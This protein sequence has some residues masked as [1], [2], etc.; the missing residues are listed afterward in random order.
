MARTSKT[1]LQK[2][3][4][5][6]SRA[7][8]DGTAVEPPSKEF[9]PGGC[10]FGADFKIEKT[11][12][13]LG[14]FVSWT[15]DVVPQLKEWV[16]VLVSQRPYF[17]RAWRKL[18]KGRWVARNHGLP[19]DVAM[20]PPS[21]DADV[22]FESPAPRQGDEKKIKRAP[23]SPNSKK[24][25][26]NKRSRQPKGSTDALSSDSIHRLRDE[27]EEEEDKSKLVACMRANVTVQEAS[28]AA[29]AEV[30][31]TR[32]EE[33]EKGS[34]AGVSELEG[35]SVLHHE[36]FLRYREDLTHHEAGVRDLAEKRDTYKLLSEK[37]QADLETA[38]REHTEIADQVIRV[39]HDSED[40]MDIVANNPI[41]QLRQRLEQIGKFKSQVDTIQAEAEE[42]KKNMDILASKKE[43]VQ[44]QQESAKT[45]LQAAKEKIS[46]QVNKI[47]ELQSL[48]DSAISDK[49]NL[50]KELEA[51]K[52]GVVMGRT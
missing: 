13:I 29:G 27:S 35:A 46:V 36:T 44:A 43:V 28:E 48:L 33:V 24:K 3:K 4:A 15:P 41:L 45:Q 14:Q 31:P 49:E 8:G 20:R 5:S 30:E 6:S 40:K 21:G 12:S 39:L 7:A 9:V 19:K 37:L 2:E 50:A 26:L 11:P 25:K 42:F 22:P 18:S 23:S 52:S 1:V 32:H 47:E 16:E 51:D 17:E 34:L 10:T 38:W